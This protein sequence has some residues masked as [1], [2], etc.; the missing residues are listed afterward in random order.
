MSYEVA[1]ESFEG[2]LDLLLFLIQ[3]NKIDIYDIPIVQVTKQYLSYIYKWQ[4]MDLEIASEFIV[5]ASRLLEIKSRTLLPRM[6]PEEESEEEMRAALVSQLL[7]YQVFKKISTY[8]EDREMAELGTLAKEPEYIPGL[9]QE[10]PVEIKG[11]DLAKAF[12]GI[13]AMYRDDH[14][15]KSY[16]GQI[17]RDNFTVEEKIDLIRGRFSNGRDE[18]VPFSDLLIGHGQKEEVVVTLLAVLELYKGGQIAIKQRG[19]FQEIII[20]EGWMV[21]GESTDNHA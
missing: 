9:V 4:E 7:D 6:T 2:P 20:E 15:L 8:L 12:R 17:L 5:M 21:D 11:E 1:L 16:S 10:K 14:L 19:L 13:I 3:K 18:A